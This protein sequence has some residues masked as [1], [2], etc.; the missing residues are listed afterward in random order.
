MYILNCISGRRTGSK[1]VCEEKGPSCACHAPSVSGIT[2]ITGIA[3]DN[4]IQNKDSFVH[5]LSAVGLTSPAGR[6][7]PACW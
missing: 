4:Y 2:S 3:I 1:S 6:V 7:V 5:R